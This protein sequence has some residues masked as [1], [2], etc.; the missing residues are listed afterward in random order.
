[1]VDGKKVVRKKHTLKKLKKKKAPVKGLKK[2]GTNGRAIQ[3][4]S[5]NVVVN[6]T[7]PASTRRKRIGSLP[8]K[9]PRQ[10]MTHMYGEPSHLMRP[11]FSPYDS[12]LNKYYIDGVA[13]AA[14]KSSES[15]P[16]R[17]AYDSLFEKPD[18]VKIK[19]E[20]A[21]V[22]SDPPVKVELPTEAPAGGSSTPGFSTPPRTFPGLSTVKREPMTKGSVSPHS[23][24]V[25]SFGF[26]PVDDLTAT[27]YSPSPLR[28]P[29][30]VSSTPSGLTDAQIA[31]VEDT[32]NLSKISGAQ[33]QKL[34]NKQKAMFNPEMH[35]FRQGRLKEIRTNRKNKNT[36]SSAET[37]SPATTRA[38]AESRKPVANRTR[39][40]I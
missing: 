11:D 32:L 4:V 36:S 34:T 22:L 25:G 37:E 29:K 15:T 14:K 33:T 31:L 26:I 10:S 13:P 17:S 6:V 20:P 2:K 35:K 21:D 30:P 5:Q 9:Q 28:T 24:S 1:M 23:M 39:S 19:P 7:A 16:T 40:R 38:V 27:G 8:V 3:T 18:S 12:M